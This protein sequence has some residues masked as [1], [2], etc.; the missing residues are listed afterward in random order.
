MSSLMRSNLVRRG[1]AGDHETVRGLALS[2]GPPAGEGSTF[3]ALPHRRRSW[4]TFMAHETLPEG[5][6]EGELADPYHRR[7][8]PEGGPARVWL[9]AQLAPRR[10]LGGRVRRPRP[11]P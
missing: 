1:A 8:R 9:G 11:T 6:R 5:A 4:C 10:T 7:W 2:C 3:G